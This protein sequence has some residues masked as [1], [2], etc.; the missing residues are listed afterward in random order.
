MAEAPTPKRL[1]TTYAAQQKLFLLEQ[2]ELRTTSSGTKFGATTVLASTTKFERVHDLFTNEGNI[3]KLNNLVKK[4]IMVKGFTQKEDGTISISE[5]TKIM[6]TTTE[7]TTEQINKFLQPEVTEI[8]VIKT[9][10]KNE[11]VS[12]QGS[13]EKT[14]GVL[15]TPTSRRKIIT[16]IDKSG[17]IDVKLWG[18]KINLLKGDTGLTITI[19]GLKVDLYN[20]RYSLN[21]TPTT[22]AEI[23][24]Q[25]QQIHGKVEAASFD[26]EDMSI[27]IQGEI[28]TL[29]ATKM[30]LVFPMLQFVADKVVTIAVQGV[31]V[32]DILDVSDE[33][34]LPNP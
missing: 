9:K 5:N 30:G 23:N 32:T 8:A 33:P 21:S 15:E 31:N 19:K 6:E 27:M 10:Q 2:T 18:E 22:T 26:Y 11:R 24:Q 4:T 29:T 1:K 28:Y 25:V 14:T 12:V 20:G 13:I 17:E 7:I 34:D 3:G 16:I